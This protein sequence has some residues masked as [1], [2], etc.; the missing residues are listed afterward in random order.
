MS[1]KKQTRFL[2]LYE[3]VH[4]RFERFC[5]ARAYSQ[6][7]HRDVMHESLLVAYERLD[8]LRSEGAFFSFL[9]GIC[10]RLLA[11]GHRKMKPELGWDESFLESKARSTD[12]PEQATEV[13]LLHCALAQLSEDQRESILLFEIA[14]FSIKEIAIMHGV[15]ESA[16]KQRL[17]RGRERLTQ[18]LTFESTHKRGEIR[19]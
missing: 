15:S 6:T 10:I 3:P 14:G 16:V 18:L 8:S 5:R 9:V 2:R 7:D 4:D 13:Y 19:V 11:N 17:R 1:R 12:N